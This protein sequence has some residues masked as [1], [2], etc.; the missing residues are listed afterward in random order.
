MIDQQTIRQHISQTLDKVEVD[1]P[2]E[3]SR[4]K[5]RDWFALP[6]GR[7]LLATSDRLSAFDRVLTTIPF[8]GQLL[9]QLSAFWFERTAD[10]IPNHLLQVPHPNVSLVRECQPLPVEVIVRG[11][12]T[13]VTKT[14]LWTLYAAGERSI[15]GHKLPDGLLKNSPLFKPLI[16]PTTKAAPG[17][18][19]ER[20]TCAEVVE[21]GLVDAETWER[22]QAVALALFRRGQEIAARSHFML[23]DTKYEFGLSPDGAL[24]LIDELHTP[25]S[26]RF[27]RDEVLVGGEPDQWDKEY[28]RKWYV[29]QGYQGKGAPPP[30]P[31]QVV[32]EAAQR[33]LILYEG[34]TGQAFQP[35][36]S[37][38]A[39]DVER[40]LRSFLDIEIRQ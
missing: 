31:E 37:P 38:T 39:P 3:H 16:T 11:F 1:W 26:S 12:I 36:P 4:G 2:Y 32:V 27:W 10:L 21:R 19:D 5:V 25:D 6:G 17:E 8:K 35:A 22:V 34:V 15:Y 23:V 29:Q 40:A 13:G 9:N 24:T 14:S 28:V 7:R 20:L 33:Y 30:L 18:H